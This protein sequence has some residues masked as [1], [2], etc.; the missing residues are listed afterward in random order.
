MYTMWFVS[1]NK[2]HLS[3]ARSS[4]SSTRQTDLTIPYTS[5]VW[6]MQPTE[7]KTWVGYQEA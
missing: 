1:H 3:R 6:K 2:D 4:R 7:P 5:P